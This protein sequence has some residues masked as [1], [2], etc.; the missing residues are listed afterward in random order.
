MNSPIVAPSE[1]RR[2][3]PMFILWFVMQANYVNLYI[4]IAAAHNNTSMITVVSALITGAFAYSIYGVIAGLNGATTGKKLVQLAE[5][6]FGPLGGVI[7]GA[8]IIVVPAAW[9]CFN[10][11]VATEVLILLYPRLIEIKTAIALT[12]TLIMSCNNLFG[13]SG[14][15]N[16]AQYIAAPLLLIGALIASWSAGPNLENVHLLDSGAFDLP[17]FQLIAASLLGNATWG[18]EEDFWRFAKPTFSQ[19]VVPIV[20][21]NILGLLV[22]SLAGYFGARDLVATNDIEALKQIVVIMGLGS[23]HV[24]AFLA[25]MHVTALND[26][27]MYSALNG[28]ER[29]LPMRRPILTLLMLP[30]LL[31]MTF[32]FLHLNLT[33]LLFM[34]AGFCGTILPSIGLTVWY[35]RIG[36]G[37]ISLRRRRNIFLISLTCGT[38]VGVMT[39]ANG[40]LIPGV[41]WSFG[42]AILQAWAATIIVFI[43]LTR[44]GAP[45][46]EISSGAAAE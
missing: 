21:A 16:F 30:L 10:S 43:G 3:F 6:Q 13:F 35:S 42:L 31:G 38:F 20:A 22:L 25:V 9:Y 18:N 28:M 41:G 36:A 14:I 34:I 44:I 7:S 12:L 26:S 5:D 45:T 15:L 37:H 2:P 29:F 33:D 39:S 11:V 24:A 23:I 19:C 27:N 40:S 46:R 32:A 4:G 8:I 1:K 17:A